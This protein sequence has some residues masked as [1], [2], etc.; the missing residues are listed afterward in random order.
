MNDYVQP[1]ASMK[2]NNIIRQVIPVTPIAP[3][4]SGISDSEGLSREYIVPLTL[5]T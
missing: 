5:S 3:R 4:N 2:V 1:A